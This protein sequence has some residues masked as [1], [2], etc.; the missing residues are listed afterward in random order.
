MADAAP[1]DESACPVDHKT[2]DA[3]LSQA[4]AAE[5][6]KN[7]TACPVDHSSLRHGPSKT[8]S[9][10]LTSY[11]PWSSSAPPATSE[12]NTH[13]SS[14][15]LNTNRVVSTIPR[16]VTN[17]EDCPV[18]HGA[19]ANAANHEI[20]SGVDAS[21]NW[22]YPSE[23]MFFDA[24]KRKGYDARVADMR[25]VVPIHNAVNER[26]W[27]QIKEWEAPYLIK[28]NC[29]GPKL[30]SFANKNDRMTPTARINTILGYTAPFDRHDWVID[31][32]GTRV[33]YVIDFYAG[34]PD[35]KGK[36]GPSF[37]LD[38][39]PKLNTWEGVKM[40]AMKWTGLA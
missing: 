31:R 35:A 6:S 9:Q 13:A 7:Q 15:N 33:D 2:R 26:A 16:S 36:V 10:T 3:W 8:W 5:A 24:M 28:S 29:G 27:Q 30:E 22:V 34:R 18:D 1:K 21:G 19:S 23:K 37:Y 32:C 12:T 14:S 25:T 38:V 11:L 40:R 4:R 20:E 17:S 39:R